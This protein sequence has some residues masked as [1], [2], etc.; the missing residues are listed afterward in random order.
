MYTKLLEETI[1][2]LKG[3]DL[4]DDRRATVNLGV[5]FRIDEDY[6]PDTNQRLAIYRTVA[7]AR[8]AADIDRALADVRDRYGPLPE[9]VQCLADH[10]RIRVMA[11]HL[12]VD[13]IEKEGT[14][15]VFKFRE[16]ATIDPR[17]LLSV[18]DRRADLRLVPPA[19]LKLDLAPPV[20]APAAR[21][22]NA[23]YPRDG[24]A[25]S[26]TRPSASP[27]RPPSSQTRPSPGARPG[28]TTHR[29][30]AQGGARG[31]SWW[32]VRAT[33][34]EV[35]PGFT[36]AEVLKPMPEDPRAPDGLFA[37][38]VGVMKALDDDL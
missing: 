8:T 22:E 20:I 26:P 25:G 35:T 29:P 33:A 19:S 12:R 24:R 21:S 15:V 34:G 13:T 6:I 14:T 31:P 36:K 23:P 5:E 4:E 37:R 11:D 18:V 1:R 7:Q 32:T 2:E 30:V 28:P 38:V 16:S 10:A 9:S 3:E 27:T 17:R